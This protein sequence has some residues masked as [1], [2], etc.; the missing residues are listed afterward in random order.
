MRR[1]QWILES[2]VSEF[3]TERKHVP[4]E[5]LGCFQES[6]IDCKILLPFISPFTY[7]GYGDISNEAGLLTYIVVEYNFVDA[8]DGE[9]PCDT[10][11]DVGSKFI[12][13]NVLYQRYR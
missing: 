10:A 8:V 1:I 7:N 4:P 11:D 9:C 12:G 2:G 5:I 3:I 6:Q 13:L